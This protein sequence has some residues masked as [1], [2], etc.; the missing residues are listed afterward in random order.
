[1][2]KKIILLIIQGVILATMPIYG[3]TTIDKLL[4]HNHILQQKLQMGDTTIYNCNRRDMPISQLKN[5]RQKSV[6]NV[7]HKQSPI[8]YEPGWSVDFSNVE[9][10]EQFTIIDANGDNDTINGKK[11]GIWSLLLNDQNEWQCIITMQRM[12]LTIG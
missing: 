5:N 8:I 10:W 12:Q 2:G 3:Q 6:S 7:Q 11:N 9:Q 1:M 4:I